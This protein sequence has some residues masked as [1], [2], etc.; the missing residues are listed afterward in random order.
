MNK[1][2]LAAVL[3]AA[4]AVTMLTGCGSSSGEY[5][6]DIKASDYVEL[7]D[8]KSIPVEEAKT[9][10]TDDYLN[11]YIQ[12][13]L[14]SKAS[15]EEVTDH[16]TVKSGDVVNIDYEGKIDGKDFDGGSSTGYDLTIGS[17]SFITG[18]EDGL[19]GQKTGSTA[20]LNLKF[21]DDYSNS[22]V[23]GKAVVFTVKI[24][25]IEKLVTPELT[26]DWVKNQN[27]DGVTTA[28]E[29]KAYMKQQLEDQAQ[30]TYD[31]DVQSKISQYLEDN[32]TF[33]KDPP[34]AMVDRF[35]TEITAYY[36]QYAQQYG[37]DLETFMNYVNPSDSSSDA[38]A[39]DASASDESASDASASDTSAASAATSEAAVTETSS[40]AASSDAAT[41]ATSGTE[42]VADALSA[43]SSTAGS[44]N[45]ASA[46]TSGSKAYEKTIREQAVRTAK[47]YII[48]QAIADIEK[49]NVSNRDYKSEM[50][51]EAADLGYSSVEEFKKNEDAQEYRE[52]LMSK[53]V[54]D[55]LVKNAKI[56][57]PAA[58]STDSSTG[59]SD[60]S[61]TAASADAAATSD[62]ASA[63][64]SDSA[65][66][67][68]SSK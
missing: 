62:S 4:T 1:K 55:F 12:Y 27:I 2:L 47:R 26:D 13:T 19:I 61:S 34:T 51:N 16:D 22:D 58:D 14:S 38:S 44:E 17:N 15:Y 54:M 46:A 31:S 11:M 9:E 6:K 68:A 8:Y 39:S 42:T 57:A 59:A 3:A 43:A 52:S 7:C 60:A 49:L 37:M 10:V 53:A 45:A 24:N 67:A 56:T 5:L 64:T 30:S 36:T 63:V 20:T 21:P 29:Y 23:A 18:F 66:A 48:M 35:V 28:D 41:A 40:A 25:K 33:K 65:A 50:A 32:C